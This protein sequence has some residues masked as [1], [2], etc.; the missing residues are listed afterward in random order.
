MP[1]IKLLPPEVYNKIAAGEVVERPAS[2]VKE[3]LENSIDSGASNISVEIFG[4]GIDKIT[5]SD[6]GCGI[7]K[8]DVKAAFM[9]HATS[10]IS[11]ADDLFNLNTL[12]FRGEALASIAAV[13]RV[14]MVTRTKDAE[15]GQRLSIKG[16]YIEH[17]EEK[18]SPY[19]TY[20][21]VENLFFNIPAR[22]KFLKSKRSEESEIANIA[23][24]LILANPDVS[25]KLCADGETVYNSGG[26]GVKA[27]IFCLYGKDTLES[28]LPVNYEGTELKISG[29][30]G[31]P[32]FFKA[33]RT[34]QTL[35]I[36]GRYV[37]NY[38]VTKAFSDVFGEYLMK[39]QY[40]FFVIYLT[41]DKSMI[42]VNVHPN[43]MEV[44]FT[45][46]Y[47]VINALKRAVNQ[48]LDADRSVIS[49]PVVKSATQY[50]TQTIEGG[51]QTDTARRFVSDIFAGKGKSELRENSAILKRILSDESDTVQYKLASDDETAAAAAEPRPAFA[52]NNGKEFEKG[53][54][55]LG[56]LAEAKIAGVLFNTYIVAEYGNAAYF[57]DQH[58]AHE[59]ILYDKF[60][61]AIEDRKAYSQNMLAPYAFKTNPAETQS[62][63][64]NLQ[65]IA[66]TGFEIEPF[67][68][69]SFRVLSVPAVISDIDI[70][71]FVNTLLGDLSFFKLKNSDL[72]REKLMQ[73]ACK[74][75]VKAGDSLSLNEIDALVQRVAGGE[76]ALRCPHGRP[77][78][79]CLYKLE[80]EKWFRRKI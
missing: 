67:G 63:L 47:P 4:G 23:A 20:I 17:F 14:T 78:I 28:C 55:T 73:A 43:K 51:R 13:S 65:S 21:T 53:N 1:Q 54:D 74:A 9:P 34:Y 18:G 45:N 22:A 42:D 30:V 31:K 77:I 7:G 12:G 6:N 52:E 75:A 68:K 26:Q 10:K 27:A 50:E 64:E 38:A 5:V 62:L 79:I 76:N 49:A 3:L 71:A 72:L 69:D 25:I 16:G 37:V 29:F 8:D 19:G 57:I 80:I 70:A 60:K 41:I 40:P 35:I 24:R 39:H 46:I 48:A 58:A 2:I 15:L 44:R 11:S 56:G 59:R 61:N 66:E 33:N 32:G 36:N